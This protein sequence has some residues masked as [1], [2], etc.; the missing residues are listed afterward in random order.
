MSDK[1]KDKEKGC[2]DSRARNKNTNIT[3]QGKTMLSIFLEE[4]LQMREI[5]LAG[6]QYKIQGDVIKRAINPWMAKISS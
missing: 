3:A 5:N 4:S 1:D 6:V 2:C